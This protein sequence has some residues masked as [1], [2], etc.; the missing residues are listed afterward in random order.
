[1][2]TPA[3][4][5]HVCGALSDTDV[6]GLEIDGVEVTFPHAFV[7]ADRDGAAIGLC[8]LCFEERYYDLLLRKLLTSLTKRTP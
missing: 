7:F 1:M 8:N 5:C 3:Q 2:N 4:R 6:V